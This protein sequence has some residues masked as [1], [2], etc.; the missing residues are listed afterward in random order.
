MCIMKAMWVLLVR[1]SPD[2][3]ESQRA[4]ATEMRNYSGKQQVAAPVDTAATRWPQK[5]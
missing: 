1:R 5:C 2:A 4:A 3:A